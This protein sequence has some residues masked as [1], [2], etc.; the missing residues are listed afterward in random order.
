MA[1]HPILNL[2][3]RY[4]SDLLVMAGETKSSQQVQPRPAIQN[5][6][7]KSPVLLNWVWWIQSLIP[8]RKS[9]IE[10]VII[11]KMENDI[12][13]FVQVNYKFSGNVLSRTYQNTDMKLKPLL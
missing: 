5:L 2:R 12:F 9:V 1:A 3:G 13:S 11:F 10:I 7:S 8:V 4:K 6:T